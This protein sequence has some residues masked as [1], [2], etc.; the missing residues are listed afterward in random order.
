MQRREMIKL[1]DSALMTTELLAGHAASP[2]D[3]TT[4]TT[5]PTTV[6]EP[7]GEPWTFI[8]VNDLHFHDAACAPWFE[9]TVAA[10]KASAPDA[11]FCLLGGDL[12]DEGKWEQLKG[13]HDAFKGLGIPL[14]STPGNH[15]Y[16]TDTDRTLYDRLLPGHTNQFFTHRNWQFVGLDTTEGTKWGETHIQPPT[17]EWLQ[18]NLPKLDK[19]RPTVIWTHFPLGADV[20]HR[21]LNAR[22]LL[23]LLAPLSIRAAFSGHWHAFTEKPWQQAVFTTDRCCSRFRDNH[24]GSKEKGWFVCTVHGNNLERRSVAVT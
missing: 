11:A 15:D 16:V 1:G 19:T 4:P 24:D 21:P 13:A 10:I 6:A 14:Y 2:A 18:A 22:V 7:G 23:E 17:F 12:A 8:A 3:E 20:P 5:T 9:K